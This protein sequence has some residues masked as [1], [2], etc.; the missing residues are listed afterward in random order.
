M[1]IKCIG[2]GITAIIDVV[3]LEKKV[4]ILSGSDT[5]FLLLLPNVVSNQLAQQSIKGK[6]LSYSPNPRWY[7]AATFTAY[8]SSKLK[9]AHYYSWSLMKGDVDIIYNEYHNK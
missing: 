2:K 3:P 7:G 4:R 5:A 6:V 8:T 9:K 1:V